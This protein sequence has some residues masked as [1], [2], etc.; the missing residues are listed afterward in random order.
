[1]R[2]PAVATDDVELQQ[3][4]RKLAQQ[5]NVLV[6]DDELPGLAAMYADFVQL[7]DTIE[8]V[9]LD[10]EEESALALDLFAWEGTAAAREGEAP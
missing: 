10:A 3:L 2:G 6:D 7:L 1:M 4:V 5:A 9:Q 8:S